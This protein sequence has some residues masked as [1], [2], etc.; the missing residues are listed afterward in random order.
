MSVV[1]SAGKEL[2][3]HPGTIFKAKFRLPVELAQSARAFDNLEYPAEY[4]QTDP[5]QTDPT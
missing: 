5:Y 3:M 4:Y 2:P 1:L